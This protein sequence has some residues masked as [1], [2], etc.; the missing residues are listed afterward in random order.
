MRLSISLRRALSSAAVTGAGDVFA[1]ARRVPAPRFFL[2]EAG[3]AFLTERF[4]RF[5]RYPDGLPLD[6][7]DVEPD[8]SARAAGRD[9]QRTTW[10]KGAGR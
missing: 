7:A 10:L 3:A 4:G 5:T 8:V 2:D 6:D 9:P 1:D